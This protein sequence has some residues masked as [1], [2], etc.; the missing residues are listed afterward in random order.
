MK[1]KRIILPYGQRKKLARRF[2]VSEGSISNA[3]LYR[4]GSPLAQSIRDA[5][6]NDCHGLII[7]QDKPIN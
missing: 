3:L 2:S 1:Q 6:I 4:T 5:A 7:E